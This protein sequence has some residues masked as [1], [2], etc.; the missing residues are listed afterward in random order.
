[1]ITVPKE[2]VPANGTRFKARANRYAHE[3]RI[4]E[5]EALEYVWVLH[6]DDDTRRRSRHRLRAR[7]VHQPPAPSDPRQDQAHG[8]GH[9]DLPRENAV[10][11]HLARG[12]RVRPADD[13]ARFRALTGMGTPAA[14]VRGGEL[15]VL[16]RVHRGRDRLGLRPQGDRRGRPPA[17]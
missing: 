17:P 10:N 1:M 13:I 4:E 9:P 11:L 5:G 2:Y 14:G 3:L 7:P 16:A 8:A 12:R 6:M 15:L